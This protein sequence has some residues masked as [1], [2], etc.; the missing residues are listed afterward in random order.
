MLGIGS[1]FDPAKPRLRPG[2]HR[3]NQVEITDHGEFSYRR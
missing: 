1:L 3:I 2:F